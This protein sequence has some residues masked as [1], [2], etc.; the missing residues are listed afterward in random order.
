MIERSTDMSVAAYFDTTIWRA[1]RPAYAAHWEADREGATLAD[2]GFQAR[3]EDW[4][5][6]A[7]WLLEAFERPGCFG[8][9]LRAAGRT[10]IRIRKKGGLFRGYGYQWRTD[11]RLAPGSWGLGY[12]GQVLALNPKTGKAPIKFGYVKYGRNA[13]DLAEIFRDWNAAGR[14]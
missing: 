9:Y 6:F 8:D 5:R 4:G 3:F 10:Q 14:R 13:R 7:A 2:A 11:N 12:A 1:V